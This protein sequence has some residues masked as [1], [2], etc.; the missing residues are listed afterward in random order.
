MRTRAT[1]GKLWTRLAWLN[2][3]SMMRVKTLPTTRR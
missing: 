1:S 2:A 3:R